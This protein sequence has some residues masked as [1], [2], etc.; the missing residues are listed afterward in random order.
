[1]K[2]FIYLLASLLLIFSTTLLTAQ[3]KTSKETI[4]WKLGLALYSYNAS[5]LPEEL[6]FAKKSGVKTIEGFS[7]EKQVL[8]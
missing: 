5:S 8:N 2:K 7:F 6:E 1:M 4:S 3:N